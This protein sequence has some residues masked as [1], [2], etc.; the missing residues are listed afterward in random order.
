MH[1]KPLHRRAG[2]TVVDEGAPEQALGNRRRIAVGQND[3][4]VIAAHS[5]VS[6]F[7]VRAAV[8][9]HLFAGRARPG[10]DDLADVGMGGHGSADIGQLVVRGDDVQH[11]RRQDRVQE[12]DRPQGRQRGIGRGLDHHGIAGAQSRQDVPDRDHHRPVPRCDRGDDAKGLAVQ[13]HP[14]GVVVLQAP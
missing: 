1:I 10:E 7:I 9:H 2:L 8:G 13:F 11:A 5:S 14:A 3:A 12:L 6:R 4:R